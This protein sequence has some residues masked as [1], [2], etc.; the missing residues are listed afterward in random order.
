[1]TR[2]RAIKLL[3]WVTSRGERTAV[4][5]LMGHSR[6][7]DLTNAGKVASIARDFAIVANIAGD[8]KRAAR[9]LYLIEILEG[10]RVK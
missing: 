2:K 9:A 4:Q 7:R 3:M 10:G 8:T 5:N 6:Y 1:M